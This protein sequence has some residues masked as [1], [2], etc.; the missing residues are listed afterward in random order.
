MK[1]REEKGK[2]E[3]TWK[4]RERKKGEGKG[5]GTAGTIENRKE[6]V[7]VARVRLTLRVSVTIVPG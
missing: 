5:K 3:R 4:G 6:L 1:I 2:K 7:M